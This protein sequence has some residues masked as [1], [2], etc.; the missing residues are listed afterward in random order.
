MRRMTK[1]QC[2]TPSMKDMEYELGIIETMG[3]VE[4]ILN[5]VGLYQLG[6]DT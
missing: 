1:A 6:K 3:F 2:A 5:C 4:Y